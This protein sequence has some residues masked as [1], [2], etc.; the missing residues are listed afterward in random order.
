MSAKR[1]VLIVESVGDFVKYYAIDGDYSDLDR[2]YI[3]ETGSEEEVDRLTK[4]YE[5]IDKMDP[6]DSFP[7]EEVKDGAAV[8]CVGWL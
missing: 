4:I 1:T 3:N 5:I 2:V 6:F 7:V 8:I